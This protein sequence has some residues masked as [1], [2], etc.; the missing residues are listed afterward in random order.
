MGLR[1]VQVCSIPSFGTE[2]SDFPPA[3]SRHYSGRWKISIESVTSPWF[4][5]ILVGSMWSQEPPL[6]YLCICIYIY[7]CICMYMCIYMYVYGC[8]CMCMDMCACVWI[9]MH[10]YGYACVYMHMM[11]SSSSFDGNGVNNNYHCV[12]VC[13]INNY[14]F[15]SI[16]YMPGTTQTDL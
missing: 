12:C 7:A 14:H 15:L 1:W 9:C 16:L 4:P 2:L 10:V 8:V 3:A 13:V 5:L 6:T 11:S